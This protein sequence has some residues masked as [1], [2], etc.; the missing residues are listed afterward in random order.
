MIK[1]FKNVKIL[2][3]VFLIIVISLYFCCW[4]K[5]A[6]RPNVLIITIDALR[7]DHLSCYGY[8]RDTS[9]NIDSLAKEGVIFKQ[10]ISQA[11]ATHPSN[12]SFFTSSY[13][14]MHIIGGESYLN[15]A[16]I[17]LANVLNN[18]GYKTIFLTDYSTIIGAIKGFSNEFDFYIPLNENEPE[19]VTDSALNV[20]TEN[21]N[22]KFF[23]WVY[24]FGTHENYGGF[25]EYSRRYYNDGLVGKKD[26]EIQPDYS[27]E[28]FGVIPKCLEDNGITDI[29]YYIAKYDG[30][31]KLI[32]YQI[33]LILKK[34]KELKIDKNTIVILLAD[35]GESLEE[36]NLYF[37]HTNNLYDI[38]LKVPLILKYPKLIPQNKEIISQVRLIDV[39][40]TIIDVLK[41]KPNSNFG[42]EGKSLLSLILDD[43]PLTEPY[44]FGDLDNWLY[45]IRTENWK[46]IFIDRQLKKDTYWIEYYKN[47]YEFYNLKDDPYETMDLASAGGD[48]FL[49]LK[50]KLDKYVKQARV[51]QIKLRKEINP[52]IEIWNEDRR[53]KLRS[54]GYL[55]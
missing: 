47:D 37:Q 40:P 18:A 27:S 11:A 53:K 36:H 55:Q 22:K 42:M 2:I 38:S 39:M 29:S 7:P 31:L 48:K 16:K 32:D 19:K 24:Y 3:P 51:Y 10:A 35:H 50:E 14:Y 17:S 4:V 33:G 41:I 43:N 13:P 15:P 52:D 30:R 23:L 12:C 34:L 6:Q 25:S 9:P 21:R 1:I 54:L 28:I 46:L 45:S 5:K 49:F 26:I 8:K 20:L 44:A